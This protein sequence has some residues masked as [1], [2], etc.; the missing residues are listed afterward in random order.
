MK[1]LMITGD[2]KFGPGNER[3]ELQKSAVEDLAVVYWGRGSLWLTLPA[4][5]F[6]VVTAQDPFWR[7]L[8]GWWA[9]KQLHAKFNVQ[10]HTDLAAYS[11]IKHILPKIVLRHADSIRVVSNK[12]KSQVEKIGVTAKISVLPVYINPDEVL[13][14][15]PSALRQ[16]YPQFKKIVL[17]SSRL[18]PE[19]NVVAAIEAQFWVIHDELFPSGLF[20]AGEGS[21]RKM[22]EAKTKELGIDNKVIFLGHRKDMFS[23]YKSADVLVVPSL[24][25]GYGASIVEALATGVPVVSADVGIA[26]EAGA[27][28]VERKDFVNTIVSVLDKGVRGHLQLPV[29]NRTEWIQTWIQT[30]Q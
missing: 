12:I 25:E 17:V 4:G 2:K 16:E 10:V 29:L 21:Q 24:Y 11:G 20:I 19:K 5:D 1:V 6:D 22:L 13:A 7:G 26:K 3:Y 15:S 9:A 18:E 30:L 23:L 28:V 27:I 14:A 8:F